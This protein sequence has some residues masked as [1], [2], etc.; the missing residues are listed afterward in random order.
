MIF[1]SALDDVFS[2]T[3][4]RK[5]TSGKLA[6]NNTSAKNM[7]PVHPVLFFV[8]LRAN[9]LKLVLSC[10][11]EESFKKFLGPYGDLDDWQN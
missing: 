5:R 4:S 9:M 1:R 7:L 10:N 6:H 2:K 8:E 3:Y 11:G